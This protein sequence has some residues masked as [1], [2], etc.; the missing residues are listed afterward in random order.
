MKPLFKMVTLLAMVAVSASAIQAQGLALQSQPARSSGA[1]HD[2]GRQA[3]VPPKGYQCC[4]TGHDV[5]VPQSVHV[6]EAIHF[7]QSDLIE[8]FP[9]AVLAGGSSL[10]TL[11]RA[12]GPPG[13]IPLRDLIR[14]KAR[15]YGTRFF[16]EILPGT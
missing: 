2:P 13:G 14:V 7:T 8:K 1:C 15:P 16:S 12:A 10:Q 5:A 11:A 4:L 9:A 6:Q 3:P